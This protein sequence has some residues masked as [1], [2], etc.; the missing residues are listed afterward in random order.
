[1]LLLFFS[2]D[3]CNVHVDGLYFFLI[4]SEW[5]CFQIG[6]VIHLYD[7][8]YVHVQCTVHAD[9]CIDMYMYM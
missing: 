4:A 9:T 3:M 8:V 2:Q 5:I 7:H 6:K 1:M